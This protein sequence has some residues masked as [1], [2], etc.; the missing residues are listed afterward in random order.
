MNPYTKYPTAQELLRK[1]L[2]EVV[3]H[4]LEHL[5][6]PDDWTQLLATILFDQDMTAK[7]I[8][9]SPPYLHGILIT[10][11]LIDTTTDPN[12]LTLLVLRD[13]IFSWH[14]S[15]L[16][17]MTPHKTATLKKCIKQYYM[18]YN[19]C[20]TTTYQPKMNN[21]IKTTPA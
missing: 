2:L 9:L 17:G 18:V 16:D 11:K 13:L 10:L 8:T 7:D 5:H 1:Q 12:L 14:L 4:A 19:R 20:T 6:L 15:K 21:D 3:A